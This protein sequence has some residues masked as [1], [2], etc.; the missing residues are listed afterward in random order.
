MLCHI[1]IVNERKMSPQL[2]IGHVINLLAMYTQTKRR[3]T[4]GPMMR[5]FETLGTISARFK[6]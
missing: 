1:L 3:L 2:K 5:D 4:E 6:C